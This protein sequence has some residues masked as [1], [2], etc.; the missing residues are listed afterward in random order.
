MQHRWVSDSLVNDTQ[1]A[2]IQCML[3]Y[4]DDADKNEMGISTT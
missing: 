2:Q 4:P 3:A 1:S